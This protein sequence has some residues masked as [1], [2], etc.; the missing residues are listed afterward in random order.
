[1]LGRADFRDWEAFWIFA[2]GETS[3]SRLFFC[4]SLACLFRELLVELRRLQPLAG[5]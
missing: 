5:F 1:M 4:S 2:S 3:S